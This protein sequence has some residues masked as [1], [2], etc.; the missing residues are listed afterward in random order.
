MPQSSALCA[1]RAPGSARVPKPSRPGGAPRRAWGRRRALIRTPLRDKPVPS[2]RCEQHFGAAAQA[3]EWICGDALETRFRARSFD[4]VSMQ[5]PALPQS[6]RKG[7]RAEIARHGAPGWAAARRLPRPRRRA[8]RAYEVP[9]ASTRRTVWAPTTWAGCSA[10]TSRSSCT[11]SSRGSTPRSAPRTSPMSS[12]A[13]GV[14][15][16][17]PSTTPT[18][19]DGRRPSGWRGRG[20]LRGQEQPSQTG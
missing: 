3:A 19:T 15:D 11:R 20:G 13:P 9:G 10:T 4:L 12:C 7:Q 14:A 2:G 1:I 18:Y 16:R 6:R 5:Y 17:R 8:P